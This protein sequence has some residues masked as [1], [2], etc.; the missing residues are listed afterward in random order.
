MYLPT[1]FFAKLVI[2]DYQS[3]NKNTQ[4]LRSGSVSDNG[5]SYLSVYEEEEGRRVGED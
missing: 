2:D 3:T 5:A 1:C 4:L